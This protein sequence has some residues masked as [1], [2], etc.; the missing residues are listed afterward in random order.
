[1]VQLSHLYMTTGKNI[2]LTIWTFVSK[3]TS[4]LFNTVW[5]CERASLKLNIKKLIP[6]HL[7]PLLHGKEWGKGGSRDR[8]PLLGKSLWMVT[9]A[10]ISENV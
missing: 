10:M 1:M 4:L 6:W 2:A 7:A 3:V 8:F 9:A 5:I